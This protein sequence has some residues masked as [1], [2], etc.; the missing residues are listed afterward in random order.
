[1]DKS[2]KKHEKTNFSI[3]EKWGS[4]VSGGRAGFT[5]VPDALIRGQGELGISD[6]E[7]VVLLNILMYWWQA[8][9]LPFVSSERIGEATG[10]DQRSVQRAIKGLELKGF[11]QRANV[12][13]DSD[14][15]NGY[16]LSGLIRQLEPI[17]KRL[18]IMNQDKS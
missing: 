6:R 17:A 18:S 12:D 2:T 9:K 4:I 8:E 13:F 7:M 1:M 16:E 11:L 14:S 15:R 3:K 5:G 10:K